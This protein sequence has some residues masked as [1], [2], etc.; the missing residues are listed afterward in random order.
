MK[1][2]RKLFLISILVLLPVFLSGCVNIEYLIDIE[3]DGSEKITLKI[4]VPETIYVMGG[5]NELSN[6]LTKQGYVVSTEN[7]GSNTIL[8]AKTSPKSGQW[9]F[10]YP[11]N[12]SRG[13]LKFVPEYS[14]YFFFRTYG[15]SATFSLDPAKV[16]E[17]GNPSEFEENPYLQGQTFNMGMKYSINMPG[18]IIEQN[19]N[20]I[21]GNNM[22]WSVDLTNDDY[23]NISAKSR[24]IY[25]VRIAGALVI[26]AVLGAIQFM[27]RKRLADSQQ[28]VVNT[29]AATSVD[30]MSSNLEHEENKDV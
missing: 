23:I 28:N 10:P 2:I 13:D 30:E 1:Y 20:S 29:D 24:V 27:R 6:Q 3:E 22:Q 25:P 14:D 16:G 12:L 5:L 21:D 4:T 17:M 8:E 26:I 7:E 18:K 11:Q 15:L 9:I 19:A